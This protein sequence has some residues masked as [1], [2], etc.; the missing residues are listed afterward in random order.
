MAAATE[1]KQERSYGANSMADHRVEQA[2]QGLSPDLSTKED[3]AA[4]TKALLDEYAT[5]STG[6]VR[7]EAEARHVIEKAAHATRNG[8]AKAIA[9]EH[10]RRLRPDEHARNEAKAVERAN[11]PKVSRGPRK[12]YPPEVKAWVKQAASLLGAGFVPGPKQHL[13]VR[14]VVGLKEVEDVAGVSWSSLQTYATTGAI[15]KDDR[16]QLK[17]LADQVDDVGARNRN[18]AAILCVIMDERGQ[19]S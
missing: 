4:F 2:M 14:E 16:E 15:V 13:A 18:L 11:R 5:V 1:E 7:R 8:M 17:R 19:A 10:V 9:E 12:T 3:R 6:Q